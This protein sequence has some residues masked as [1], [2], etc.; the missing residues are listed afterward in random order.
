[1]TSLEVPTSFLNNLETIIAHQNIKLI[2]EI[3]KWKGWDSQELINEFMGD[4]IIKDKITKSKVKIDNHE[5]VTKESNNQN[6]INDDNLEIRYRN[7]CVIG[8]QRY[9][10]ESP[11]NNVYS[12]DGEF[13]GKKHG[14]KIDFDAEED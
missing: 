9:Y 8:N 12:I 7:I 5:S 2:T 4:T 3:C 10:I 13:K 6:I 14:D 11:T 1:M